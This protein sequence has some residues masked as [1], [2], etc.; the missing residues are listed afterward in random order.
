MEIVLSEGR[1]GAISSV[2]L[3]VRDG[4]REAVNLYESLGFARVGRRRDYYGQ[5]HDGVL[6]TLLLESKIDE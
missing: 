3:E 6:M 2:T 5:G 4:N 1:G